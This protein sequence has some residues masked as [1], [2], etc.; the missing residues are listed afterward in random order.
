MSDAPKRAALI[1]TGG[2]ARAAYQVGVLKA[3]AEWLPAESP[4]PFP[5]IVG[6]SAGAVAA[7]ALSSRSANFRSA[8]AALEQVWANFHVEQ[9]FRADT[10]S[11]LRAGL[12]WLLAFVSSGLLLPPPKSLFDNRP[13]R[14]LLSRTMSF[15]GV[16]RSMA[17][18]RLHAL[19][20]CATSFSS[21]RCVT[22]YE[23]APEL[24]DWARITGGGQRAHLG[25]DHLMASLSIPF[26]F[27]AVRLNHEYYGDGAMRQ[28]NPLSPAI[29]LGAERL[30]VIGVRQS[31]LRSAFGN[32]KAGAAPTAGQIF[33]YMLDTLFMD[34]IYADIEQLE[35]L[36]DL[37]LHAPVSFAGLRA[38]D[39]MVLAPSRDLREVA[40]RHVKELPRPL[41]AL[42][43]VI[44]AHSA[45][46]GSLGSYLMFEAGYTRELI[47]LGY[48]DANAQREDILKLVCHPSEVPHP[49]RELRPAHKRHV[50]SE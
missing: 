35:R 8:V 44:G 26:L 17:K 21:G 23:G 19:G 41:R 20:I 2:G 12:H 45:T 6:T 3:L 7:V 22:F 24:H 33:G 39:A 13:L 47:A 29:N 49:A 4:C 18:G 9:V 31:G 11:M 25:L 50:T 46:T 27:P 34:Q 32:M 40:A 42:L 10:V 15:R 36:N 1:L 48:A 37:V 28:T 38:I 43:R 30:L 16:H 14:E 5:I